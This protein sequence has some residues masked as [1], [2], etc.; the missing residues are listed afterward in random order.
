MERW[1]PTT[2]RLCLQVDH[3]DPSVLQSSQVSRLQKRKNYRC[4]WNCWMSW[5]CSCGRIQRLA[6]AAVGRR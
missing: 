4:Y 3:F 2:R 6:L 5:S 1:R